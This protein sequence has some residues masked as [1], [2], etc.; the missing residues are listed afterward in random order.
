M[1]LSKK[2]LPALV[3]GALSAGSASAAT[4]SGVIVFGDSLSDGGFYR[5]PL[6]LPS[7]L[8]RFTT[9][10]GFTAS[11]LIAQ[12]YGYNITPSNAGGTNYAQG[13]QRVNGAFPA[14]TPAPAPSRPVSTQITEYLTANGGK[15][16]PNA[17]YS[18]WAG[19]ND[20]F[21][22]LGAVQTGALKP[23]DVA[24]F[25]S[26]TANDQIRNIAALRAAGA[27][28]ILVFALPDIG[29]TP[30]FSGPATAATTTQLSV[31]YNTGL[32]AGLKANGI[33]VI[34]VDTFTL[35]KEIMA[36]PGIYGFTNIT[37]PA[38]L[39]N[40]AITGDT[41]SSLFC[42]PPTYRAANANQT[43]LFADGVHPSSAAHAILGQ[44]VVSLIEG[45]AAVG[46]LAES[47]LH[48]RESHNRTLDHGM[49][50]ALRTGEGKWAP[51]LG[52]DGGR[53]DFSRNAANGGVSNDNTSVSAGLVMRASETTA[54]G[55]ALGQT[56]ADASLGGG[57]GGYEYTDNQ[58]SAFAGVRSGAAYFSA[59][60]TIGDASYKDY[61]RNIALGPV[62]RVATA[63]PKGSNFSIAVAGG[64]DFK[65]GS[66]VRVGPYATF[67]S[68]S[69]EV[70][71]FSE[72]GAGSANLRYDSQTRKSR[73][74]S[75]GARAVGDFGNFTP[76]A[77]VAFES[78]QSN[79]ARNVT[80][81]PL[82]LA[83]GNSYGI[84]TYRGDKDWATASI[85]LAAKLGGNISA[86]LAYNGVF[87]RKDVKADSISAGVSVGF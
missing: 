85:G 55:F 8:G 32:F 4:F 58:L 78:E 66:N 9:N 73:I 53:Y 70:Q 18:M 44:F 28:Y 51:F 52:I 45:P 2:L 12:N 11:E 19:A 6:R 29:T 41:G 35:L 25:V 72:D 80:A 42:S 76:F 20:I 67:T 1:A 84:P 54:V 62:T 10:P 23:E 7:P 24:S 39:P 75:V 60:G 38:C 74:F 47:A 30:Q 40:P 59:K 46:M 82:S 56:K 43:Y 3:A 86:T 83:T 27:R 26:T 71:G 48:S 37:T 57:L 87:S 65:V 64:Y 61:K 21:F 31:G 17:L 63:S 34:P 79:D 50:A 81:T 15:A 33:E 69:V 77:R 5:V 13:G 14:L 49:S 68:Q 22:A 16:D 36:N